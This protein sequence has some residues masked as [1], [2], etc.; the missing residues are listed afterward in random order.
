LT[1]HLIF[2]E[3]NF[4]AHLKMC[5]FESSIP[6]TGTEYCRRACRKAQEELSGARQMK[7]PGVLQ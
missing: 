7:T 3:K 4:R 6:E 2:R 1:R 5:P